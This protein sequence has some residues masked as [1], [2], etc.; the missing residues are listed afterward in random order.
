MIPVSLPSQTAIN[1]LSQRWYLDLP[2]TALPNG[3]AT[4]SAEPNWIKS[5]SNVSLPTIQP[6]LI[7]IETRV[8][9]HA[10]AI[11]FQLSE[12]SVTVRWQGPATPPS[13]DFCRHRHV[14]GSGPERN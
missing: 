5:L 12:L 1:G 3:A 9:C 10:R 11:T 13:S 14:L 6:E 8:L 7:E 2:S 4:S